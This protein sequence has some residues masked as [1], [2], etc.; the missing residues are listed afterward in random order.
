MDMVGNQRPGQALGPGLGDEILKPANK[1]HTIHIGTENYSALDPS[2]DDVVHR[3]RCI[4]AGL[5]WYFEKLAKQGGI[6]KHNNIDVPSTL[7]RY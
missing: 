4:D 2:N 6:I 3:P 5:A 7:F 1:S